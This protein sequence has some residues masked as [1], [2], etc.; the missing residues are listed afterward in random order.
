MQYYHHSTDRSSFETLANLRCRT[1]YRAVGWENGQAIIPGPV[2]LLL[3]ARR[4]C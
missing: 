4:S 2:T 1:G 3:D